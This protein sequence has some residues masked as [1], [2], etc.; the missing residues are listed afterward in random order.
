MDR[1]GLLRLRE[2]VVQNFRYTYTTSTKASG[3]R[4]SLVLVPVWAVR[5]RLD[6]TRDPGDALSCLRPSAPSLAEHP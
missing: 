4:D 1:S 6:S 3:A 5:W 2:G